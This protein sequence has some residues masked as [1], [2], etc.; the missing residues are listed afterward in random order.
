MLVSGLVQYTVGSQGTTALPPSGSFW[1]LGPASRVTLP[2][3]LRAASQTTAT[4]AMIAT[5]KKGN[6]LNMNTFLLEL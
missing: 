6:V 5:A 3:E 4:V 1:P 2:D